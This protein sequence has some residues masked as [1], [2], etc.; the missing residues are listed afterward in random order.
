MKT[1]KTYAVLAKEFTVKGITFPKGKRFFL[2]K[3]NMF[4]DGIGFDK[5]GNFF[6]ANYFDFGEYLEIPKEYFIK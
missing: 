4:Y 2:R 5:D 6:Y 1:K 3:G